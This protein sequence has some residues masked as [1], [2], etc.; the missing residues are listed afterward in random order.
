MV[1][2]NP[3]VALPHEFVAVTVYVA[4]AVAV[5]GD[6]V[7]A[8]VPVFKLKPVGKAGLTEYEVA[9]PPLLLGELVVIALPGQ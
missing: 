9:I 6:P 8:P 7:I 4:D 5:V 2:F 1:I 3:S